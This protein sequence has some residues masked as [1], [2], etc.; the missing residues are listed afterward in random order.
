MRCAAAREEHEEIPS[1]PSPL[2]PA[3]IVGK[4]TN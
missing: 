4:K 3:N 1:F 2:Q